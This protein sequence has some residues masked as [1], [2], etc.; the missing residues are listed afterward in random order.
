MPVNTITKVNTQDICERYFHISRVVED[1]FYDELEVCKEYTG[2][3]AVL[4]HHVKGFGANLAHQ[5]GT[6]GIVFILHFFK[7]RNDIFAGIPSDTR[8]FN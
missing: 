1:V 2:L 7:K 4:R 8:P 3:F 5:Y 6:L